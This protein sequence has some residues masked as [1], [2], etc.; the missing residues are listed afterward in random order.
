[1]LSLTIPV[2]ALCVLAMVSLGATSAQGQE[3]TERYIPIG[4]SPGLSGTVTYTGE[5]TGVDP[6]A[7]IVTLDRPADARRVTVTVT[8]RT[9]IW[10]D[11]SSV[12]RPNLTGQFADLRQGAL[13]EIHF[14]DGEPAQ[15]ADWIKIESDRPD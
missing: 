1:M 14:Q 6:E 9:R 2:G 8:E 3:A 15:V 10:L 7:R 13:A 5:I 11:R 12:G 4:Q